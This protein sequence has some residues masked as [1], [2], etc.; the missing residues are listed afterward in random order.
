MPQYHVDVTRTLE[1]TTTIT[2]TAKDEDSAEG[3]ALT[4][5]EK[6][7]LNWN[8]TGPYD[9]VEVADDVQVDN[10]ADD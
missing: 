8:V 7:T 2:V 5:A 9:W 10:V 4:R 1:I 3:K 6:T